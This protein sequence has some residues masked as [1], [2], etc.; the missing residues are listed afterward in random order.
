MKIKRTGKLLKL[1]TFVGISMLVGCGSL[2]EKT[3]THFQYEPV[4]KIDRPT[5]S[6]SDWVKHR[7]YTQYSKWQGVRHKLGGLSRHGI[8]CSG[9]VQVTF[10]KKLGI[11]LPR[12]TRLQS[13]LGKEIRKSDLKAGDLVF[14]RTGST[15]RHVGI[16]LEKNKFLHVSER[17]GVMISKLDNVYWKSNYWKSIRI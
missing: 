6:N 5:V 11:D 10:K 7:L 8:D 4:P 3:T 2:P 12:T 15:S 1:V 13:N 17:R 14:F 9:F 16:Y